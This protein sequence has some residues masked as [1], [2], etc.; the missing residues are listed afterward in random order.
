MDEPTSGLDSKTA[1]KIIKIMKNEA[2]NNDMTVI[3]TIHQPSS[4]IFSCIDRL[5]LLEQGHQ[6]YQGPASEI[7]SYFASSLNC[8][9]RRFQNPADFII[10]LA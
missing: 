4:E 6:V 5:L 10:R 8:H 1:L 9:L 7:K 2:A 3:C